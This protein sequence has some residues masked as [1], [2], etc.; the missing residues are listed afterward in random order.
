MNKIIIVGHPA[1]GFEDVEA[2]LLRCGMKPSLPSRRERVLPREITATLCKAHHAPTA[3]VPTSE[4]EFQQLEV[5]PVWH[6]L[7]LDLLL[8][9]M[10]Q[11]LWGW[12]DAQTIFLLDH[13]RTL[14]PQA[15]FVLVYDEPQRVLIEAALDPSEELDDRRIRQRLDNWA[16]YNGAML[17][18]FL[19][20]PERCLLVQAQQVA[21]AVDF[22]LSQLQ[23][24]L[25]APLDSANLELMRRGDSPEGVSEITASRNQSLSVS[26]VTTL[27]GALALTPS[28]PA[29]AL[30]TIQA[31][32]TERYLID[33]Y[34]ADH[35]GYT[36]F[37]EELQAVANM[38]LDTQVA[39]TFNSALAWK[40]LL[41]Q[42]HLTTDILGRMRQQ[43]QAL[44][45]KQQQSAKEHGLL[46]SQLRQVQD[47]LES[48]FLEKLNLKT[49]IDQ[50]QIELK[51]CYQL[52]EK[53]KIE[54]RALSEIHQ[55]EGRKH[56]LSLN[57][58]H[59]VQD[60]LES[61]YLEKQNLKAL[62]D[63]Q[64]VELADC[65]LLIERNEKAKT[66]IFGAA[67]RVKR[68]LSYRLGSTVVTRARSVGGWI[69]M[70]FD[71]FFTTLAFNREKSMN[72]NSKLPPLNT[73]KDYHEAE[74]VMQQLS[75]RLG[76]TFL[77][78][79]RSP[80]G[81]IK[82]PFAISNQITV[83]NSSRSKR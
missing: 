73:Y 43:H 4:S 19:R 77:K 79:I 9:N 72:R 42:R 20:N 69:R 47:E 59:R 60:E 81:W 17:R 29:D 39:T 83:F 51:D 56:D 7:A 1:S 38:P 78:H 48:T 57:W 23:S 15:T 13:W 64:Q 30:Q 37:Y 63:Q 70:P 31:V 11:E 8:G 68:Q 22:Y 58:L 2:L 18:F 34:L 54:Y 80:I 21:R 55:Q 35:P 52:L 3:G 10:D 65:R 82:M 14:D 16:A 33:S 40:A 45:E 62:T 44:S 61:A 75:Y 25:S 71:L 46:L 49:L 24:R 41:A 50:Q 26:L 28:L 53:A 6:S 76:Q 27:D 12:A 5:G 36:R 32:E 66:E 74:R 67:E